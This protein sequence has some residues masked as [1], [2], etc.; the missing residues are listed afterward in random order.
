L[1][2]VHVTDRHRLDEALVMLR[3]AIRIGAENPAPRPL[4]HAV[5]H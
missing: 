1:A 5:L 2:T 4:V 3:R